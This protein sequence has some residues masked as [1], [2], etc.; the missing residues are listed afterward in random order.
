MQH[1]CVKLW[2]TSCQVATWCMSI[3]FINFEPLPM[4]RGD[5]NGTF[6]FSCL[7]FLSCPVL[8]LLSTNLVNIIDSRSVAWERSWGGSNWQSQVHLRGW[9][10]L[11]AGGRSSFRETS[12]SPKCHF[13]G[14]IVPPTEHG[15]GPKRD[16]LGCINPLLWKEL[17][18][19]VGFYRKIE[20]IEQ[21]FEKRCSIGRFS[22]PP[23]LLNNGRF[24]VSVHV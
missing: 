20:S 14:Q 12:R 15:F 13:L 1:N 22:G 11:P 23:S 10:A 17:S 4:G 24:G 2:H 21:K 8:I 18:F 7:C 16:C 6:L 5:I 19:H 9:Y 3:C